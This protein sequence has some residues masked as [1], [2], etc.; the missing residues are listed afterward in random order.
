MGIFPAVLYF[1]ILPICSTFVSRK[2]KID[3]SFQ[4]FQDPLLC[5]IAVVIP[6]PVTQIIK[7]FLEWVT[8]YC[9]GPK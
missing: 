7:H 8:P 2:N 5:E 3:F 1:P 6:P 9:T 4:S